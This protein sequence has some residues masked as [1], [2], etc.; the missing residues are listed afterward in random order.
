MSGR[1]AKSSGVVPLRPAGDRPRGLTAKDYL[2]VLDLSHAELESV[3][4]LAAQ[5]KRDRHAGRT[6][7]QPLAGKHV[8]RPWVRE[9]GRFERRHAL[10][11]VGAFE[12]GNGPRRLHGHAPEARRARASSASGFRM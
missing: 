6:G 7:T 9:G 4:D 11:L 12:P 2:S 8:A 1:A 3:L 10:E 5:L